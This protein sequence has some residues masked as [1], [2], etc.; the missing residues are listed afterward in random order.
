M[1]TPSQIISSGLL[2]NFRFHLDA[3]GSTSFHPLV[4]SL[5]SVSGS[6][7]FFE[8]EDDDDSSTSDEE[9]TSTDDQATARRR[10]RPQP[11]AIDCSIKIWDFRSGT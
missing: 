1:V 8:D 6:R 10:K 7:H 2:S 5:L 4:A 11:V 9:S 3:I